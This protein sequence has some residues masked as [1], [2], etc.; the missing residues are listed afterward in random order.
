MKFS[1]LL[2]NIDVNNYKEINIDINQ[3]KAQYNPDR[4]KF[5]K[6]LHKGPENEVLS[7]IYSPHY[8]LL[9][10]Y[11]EQNK[12][13]KNIEKTDYYKLQKLYGRNHK[14]IVNKIN[15]FINLY[16]NILNEGYKN[17]IIVLDKSLVENQYNN[18]YEIF[19][20]H[21]R[22]ACCLILNMKKI[23]CKFIKMRG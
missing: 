20:G 17:K 7:M 23:R 16:N 3:I 8:R 22:V 12:N 21:H 11:V 9:K 10:Q 4:F 15:S 5:W 18:G 2:K 19:E 1:L 13:V 6:S 14:W